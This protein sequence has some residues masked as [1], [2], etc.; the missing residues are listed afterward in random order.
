MHFQCLIPTWTGTIYSLCL[1]SLTDTKRGGYLRVFK[2][3]GSL[4]WL[5]HRF[6]STCDA[7]GSVFVF[8]FLS[9]FQMECLCS[10]EEGQMDWSAKRQ[11]RGNSVQSPTAVRRDPRIEDNKNVRRLLRNE[12][13][14]DTDA[15][16]QNGSDPEP[17][18]GKTSLCKL[19]LYARLTGAP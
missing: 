19:W 9:L 18:G 3:E 10:T 16:A 17:A 7:G 2:G 15:L 1:L 5:Y 8:Y 14:F 13:I 12:N 11:K 6:T 4:L